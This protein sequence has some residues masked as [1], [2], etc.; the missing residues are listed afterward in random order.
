MSKKSV[1]GLSENIAGLL[2]YVF[3]FFSGIVILILE[4]ENKF[5]RFHALQ[6]TIWFVF[7]CV[8]GWVLRFLAVI[9]L[10]GFFIGIIS[11]FVGVVSFV[12]WVV[13]MYMAYKG[14]TFKL[15]V[16]GD[17]VWAQVNK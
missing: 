15:P 6:S 13:L 10:L 8:L 5:V 7:I 2:S 14:D 9:P 4:K 3:M 12:S 16:I 11:W 17:V 1:F